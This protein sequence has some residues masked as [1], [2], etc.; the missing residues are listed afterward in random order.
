MTLYSHEAYTIKLRCDGVTGECSKHVLDEQGSPCSDEYYTVDIHAR[1]RLS[2]SILV[3]VG[4]LVGAAAIRKAF[5][6][7][8]EN[9]A[10]AMFVP[11]PM[12]LKESYRWVLIA[13]PASAARAAIFYAVV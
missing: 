13:E 4:K 10:I 9:S 6:E 3:P 11:P 5:T 8:L 2:A 7:S 1:D 12:R